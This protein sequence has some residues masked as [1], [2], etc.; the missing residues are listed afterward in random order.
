MS[1]RISFSIMFLAL[2]LFS[3][4][5]KSSECEL[6]GKPCDDQNPFTYFDRYTD[7]CACKGAISKPGNGVTDNLGYEYPTVIIGKQEWMARNLKSVR[8]C[9]GDNINYYNY[10]SPDFLNGTYYYEYY[11]DST[12]YYY[13]EAAVSDSRNVCPCGWHVSS[14]ADWR[15]LIQTVGG[16][17]VAG[18]VLKA[19]WG[20]NYDTTSVGN[21]YGFNAA[22]FA[23]IYAFNGTPP[24]PMLEGA[25]F[26]ASWWCDT[27]LSNNAKYF[28]T[29]YMGSNSSFISLWN[30]ANGIYSS[31]LYSV[32]CVRDN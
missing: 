7:S 21:K 27:V 22:A 25:G 32:R 19:D 4:N 2:F 20:W 28:T 17:D 1:M 5:K 23:N 6:K 18:N 15:E 10:Q 8:Y 11:M 30:G 9:N 31:R 26:A 16:Q 3:C 29:I 12:N 24:Y 13:N 14:V